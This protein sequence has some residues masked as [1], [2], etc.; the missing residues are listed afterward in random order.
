MRSALR[1]HLYLIWISYQIASAWNYSQVSLDKI[2]VGN[3]RRREKILHICLL[4]K[5]LKKSTSFPAFGT[6]AILQDDKKRSGYFLAYP[7]A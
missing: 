7:A 1:V 6:F 2:P 5:Y 3:N 4:Y